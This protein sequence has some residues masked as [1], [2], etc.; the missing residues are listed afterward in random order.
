M[1]RQE[2]GEGNVEMQEEGR[3]NGAR[4][5]TWWRKMM[6]KGRRMSEEGVKMGRKEQR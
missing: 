6:E 4:F 3:K 1:V 2:D 5:E